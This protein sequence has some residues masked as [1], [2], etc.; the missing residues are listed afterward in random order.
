MEIQI[1]LACAKLYRREAR[2]A[3][4]FAKNANEWGT[5]SLVVWTKTWATRL[6]QDRSCGDLRM[7]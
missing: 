1:R 3:H 4:S 5:R 7:P 6:R 2:S